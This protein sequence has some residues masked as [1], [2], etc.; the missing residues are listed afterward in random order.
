MEEVQDDSQSPSVWGSIQDLTP[1]DINDHKE[2][3]VSAQNYTAGPGQSPEE[4][5]DHSLKENH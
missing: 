2:G 3:E 5:G 1:W 4:I